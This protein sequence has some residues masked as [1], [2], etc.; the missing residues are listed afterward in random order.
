MGASVL[1]EVG[2]VV[3]LLGGLIF[4]HELGHFLVAKAFGVKVVRF[5]LGFGPRILGFTRGETDYRISLLPLGGYVKMAG[6]DPSEE[7]EGDERGRGFL[8]QAPWKRILISFA[9]PAM[10][11]AFP[12]FAYFAL[13]ALQREQLPAYVGKVLPEMP[14]FAAGLRPGDRIVEIDGETLYSFADLQRIVQPSAGK[15]LALVV[16]REGVRVPLAMTPDGWEERDPLET[17]VIGRIGMIAASDVAMVALSGPGTALWDAGLRPLDLVTHVDETAVKSWEQADVA[18]RQAHGAGRPVQVRVLRSTAV[19]VAALQLLVPEAQRFT[20]APGGA[21]GLLPTDL[22]ITH[23]EPG[24]A[25][26][27]A[28]LRRGDRLTALDERPLL[29]WT[30]L[31]RALMEKKAQPFTLAWVREGAGQQVTLSQESRTK[32]DP[33]TDRDVTLFRFGAF[34]RVPSVRPELVTVPFRPVLALSMAIEA[35]WDVGRKILLGVAKIFTGEIAFK[36]VGGP[37]EIFQV[38][39][40][41]AEAG[42]E[43]Y[44]HTMA[45]ISINLGLINLFP[46]PVLDGGH[47]VAGIIETVRRRPLSLRAREIS[48]LVGLVL[49]LTLMAFAIKNDVVRYFFEG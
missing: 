43:M 1:F 35:S 42:W 44:L 8:E 27:A 48:N 28:G 47:I 2:S 15:R 46:V 45:M 26:A 40:A 14:A 36:N 10:N 37:L 19:E 32:L 13:F 29:S 23:V 22:T 38:T 17:R 39:R 41:A 5:S 4:V 21:L 49:L 7:L 11:L 9:G 12:V 24:S 18:L 16:E 3:L 6:D 30:Q 20:V 31:E 34:Q 33:L 25:A